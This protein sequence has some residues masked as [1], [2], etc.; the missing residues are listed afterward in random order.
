MKDLGT[1]D[2]PYDVIGLGFG[3][4]NIALAIAAQEI[5]PDRSCLFLERSPDVC[6]HEGML[7]DGARMQISFLKDLVSLRNLASPFTFLAYQKAKGRLEKFVNLGQF[8]PTRLEFQDY[9]RWVGGQFAGMVRYRSA[10]TEVSPVRDDDGTLSLL[11]VTATDTA[12]G[13]VAEYHARN[14]VHALGGVP[15]VPAGVTTGPA[16]VHSS[17]FLSQFPG[18]FTDH[19]REWEFAVAGD[20]QSAG[21]ITH[22]LLDRYRNS[23]VHL[24]LPGYSLRATDNNPFA[25]EQFFEANVDEFYCR[26]EE[27][28]RDYAARLRNTNYGVVEAGFLDTLYDVV[29][30]DEVRGR[31]RLVVHD[32]SRLTRTDLDGERVRIGVHS[33]FGAGSHEL[34]ADGLVLATGY[35]RE[36]DTQ[37]YQA[38]LPY[39]ELDDDSRLVVSQD[40]RVRAAEEL[41]CGLYVQGLAEATQG[42]GDTLLSLLPF[43]SK[44][45]VTAI[46]KD[47]GSMARA[48]PAEKD[49]SEAMVAQIQRCGSGTVV[50][51]GPS[52]FPVATRLPL[53]LDRARGRQGVLFG[54]LDGTDPMPLSD[55]GKVLV[56]F[57]PDPAS[58]GPPAGKPMSVN[59]RGH[60][61]LVSDGDRIAAH[62]ARF[63]PAG[64]A[65]PPG[66]A[67]GIEIE[68]GMLSGRVHSSQELRAVRTENE[69]QS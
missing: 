36:L 42:L 9:L 23:R 20:G 17:A 55:G 45:I 7:I 29:Y 54:V 40:H 22:Y 2:D 10:V 8:R 34:R 14:V 68:I 50:S 56:V 24:V 61:R 48:F 51:A 37:M 63:D 21:E 25:N 43:R 1:R 26:S 41:T 39:L 44:Q 60:V 11:R 32:G 18:A 49:D 65:D 31:T 46:A 4:S 13:E 6:W 62:L 28:R 69:G 52:E 3:P 58:A 5:A 27:N 53:I 15:M 59:V 64:P 33:R 12:T 19:D 38:V 66:A 57:D 35:R 30:A 16:V 47:G 67:V